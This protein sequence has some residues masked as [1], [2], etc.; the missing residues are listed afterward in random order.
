M[1]GNM[2]STVGSDASRAPVPAK[3][4]ALLAIAA[5]VQHGGLDVTAELVA[6]ARRRTRLTWRS[7]TPF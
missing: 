5:A 4:K 6:R 2:G 3:L 7:T 1:I